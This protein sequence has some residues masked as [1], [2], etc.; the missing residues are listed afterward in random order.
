MQHN[1]QDCKCIYYINGN[2]IN[3]IILK[4]TLTETDINQDIIDLIVYYMKYIFKD[5]DR[6]VL[7]THYA[8]DEYIIAEHKHIECNCK[9]GEYKILFLVYHR[10]EQFINMEGK[11]ELTKAIEIIIKNEEYYIKYYPYYYYVNYNKI[12]YI[13]LYNIEDNEEI[14]C[15]EKYLSQ[16]NYITRVYNIHIIKTLKKMLVIILSQRKNRWLPIELWSYIYHD[17][18]QYIE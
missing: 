6:R 15:I 12:L 18:M 5:Y 4:L 11:F 2:I 17:F 3:Q 13:K 10:L 8:N 14:H 1:N 16:R 9:N 7:N